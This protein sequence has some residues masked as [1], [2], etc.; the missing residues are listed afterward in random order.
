M[1]YAV[2]ERI[3]IEGFLVDTQIYIFVVGIFLPYHCM[4]TNLMHEWS[5]TISECTSF[6]PE[7]FHSRYDA[8]PKS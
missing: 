6:F 8:N 4:E 7:T 3:I 2:E 1:F 5:L